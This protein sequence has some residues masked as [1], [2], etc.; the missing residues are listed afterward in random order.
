MYDRPVS[1][2]ALP[3]PIL[4]PKVFGRAGNEDFS[5]YLK[6]FNDACHLNG[7][8][9][10]QKLLLLPTRLVG[11]SHELLETILLSDAD[12]SFH[13]A[14]EALR[15]HLEPP[16]QAQMHEAALR[17][18]LK[19]THE[20]QYAYAMELCRLAAKAYPG[21]QGPLLESM[22][23]QI[24][25]DGHPTKDMRLALS[26]PRPAS[27]E[28]EVQKAIEVSA[29]YAREQ[30]R[31]PVESHFTQAV[32]VGDYD[33]SACAAL[34]LCSQPLGPLPAVP[35][36]SVAK[37]SAHD[38]GERDRLAQVLEK[39]NQIMTKLEK[40]L[41]RLEIIVAPQTLVTAGASHDDQSRVSGHG[42]GRG[43]AYGRGGRDE[44]SICFGCRQP[45]H[46][47]VDC[48]HNPWALGKLSL[49]G[50]VGQLPVVHEEPS[51]EVQI[52]AVSSVI[53]TL[54]HNV[55]GKSVTAL[56]DSGSCVSLLHEQTVLSIGDVPLQAA[57]PPPPPPFVFGE[58]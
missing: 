48:P 34:P 13:E 22:L 54:D 15:S 8:S 10:E 49:T 14:V 6:H 19:L 24:F 50:G 32:H 45:G 18:R 30:S 3:R 44:P 37:A 7:Y 23:L 35:R 2:S 40:R 33:G 25:I 55:Q 53:P 17:Q 38:A 11:T 42:R 31:M 46:F 5:A 39:F 56:I 21:Q 41:G 57:P 51:D 20:T 16:Q 29:I 27:I 43:R 58:W 36:A 4:L 26:S 1:A 47:A 28:L 9:E 12:I 52:E